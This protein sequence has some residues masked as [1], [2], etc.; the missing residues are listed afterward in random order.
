MIQ[1]YQKHFKCSVLR[2]AAVYSDWCEF[3][4]LYEFLTCWLSGNW[5]ARFLA[6]K[7]ES[8]MTY[9]HIHDL[10]KMVLSLIQH[11][12]T[13]PSYQVYLC[14]PPGSTSHRELFRIATRYYFGNAR[15]PLLIPGIFTYPGL[16]VKYIMGYLRIVKMPHE[17][18][19]ML[20]YIDR[21]LTVDNT[22]TRTL[23]EWEPS[24]RFDICRRLLFLIDHMKSQPNVWF[25]RNQAALSVVTHRP[26]WMIYET[27]VMKEDE[28]ISTLIQHIY[29]IE[30]AH[31][32]I[33][34]SKMEES[35]LH[36]HLSTLYHLLL[37]S[38]RTS[39]RMLMLRHIDEL[40][41]EK[42]TDGAGPQEVVSVLNLI[43]QTVT[44]ELHSHNELARIKQNIYDLVT[45]TL[46]LARD[47][48]E[49]MYENLES[50]LH[51]YQI[52]GIP[53]VF[54]QKKRDEMIRK[55]SVFYQEMPEESTGELFP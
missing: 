44:E 18:F 2:L 55:L 46:Q 35:A 6:G 19:W 54:E 8:A 25:S 9:I 36:A 10:C 51:Q 39:E 27:L 14:S 29:A 33:T 16:L 1:S 7:G 53:V 41:L 15:K 52:S 40:I 21:T 45:L 31:L 50:I 3:A 22:L 23:L 37:A 17:K 11:Q 28:L 26:N 47:E 49:D 4:P 13:I 43:D 20:Q 30:N 24:P 5:D 42:F 48:V 34:Y 32:Y 12:D 38:V